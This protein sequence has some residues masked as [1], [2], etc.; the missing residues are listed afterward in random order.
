[1]FL[2]GRL[3]QLWLRALVSV[4]SLINS[5]ASVFFQPIWECWSSA[6][7]LIRRTTVFIVLSK[8]QGYVLFKYHC[9]INT[10]TLLSH[11]PWMTSRKTVAP[12]CSLETSDCFLPSF[13]ACW[14]H[15][16]ICLSLQDKIIRVRKKCWVTL[17]WL[18]E[19]GIV[20]GHKRC[21]SYYI[22]TWF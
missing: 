10:V 5:V 8:R 16:L 6:C 22:A 12:F 3:L 17:L 19:F 18:S 14:S 21:I 2:K 15:S 4:S 7:S 11:F 13:L 1:M 9:H 20:Q